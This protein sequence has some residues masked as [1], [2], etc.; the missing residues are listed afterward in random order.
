MSRPLAEELTEFQ[1]TLD[2][3][4]KQYAEDGT[5][6]ADEHAHLD[7]LEGKIKQLVSVV[8]RA[9]AGNGNGLG[10]LDTGQLHAGPVDAIKADSEPSDEI[11]KVFKAGQVSAAPIEATGEAL[12]EKRKAL[13]KKVQDAEKSLEEVTE[14]LRDMEKDPVKFAR[15]KMKHNVPSPYEE[16][17]KDTDEIRFLDDLK[18]GTKKAQEYIQYISDAAKYVQEFGDVAQLEK[19][20]KVAGQLK[21][22]SEKLG[23]PLKKFE[24]LIVNLKDV[25]KWYEAASDF[26]DATRNLKFGPGRQNR[27]TVKAWVKS[28]QGV[29]SASEPF[30]NWA[31]DKLTGA[32]SAAL[33]I[34]GAQLKVGLAALDAGVKVVS[35]YLDRYDEIMKKIDEAAHGR[36]KTPGPPP[37]EPAVWQSREERAGEAR[38]WEITELTR[39]AVNERDHAK[40]QAKEA[41][42]QQ[43]KEAREAYDREHK[44]FIDEFEAKLFPP[45]YLQRRPELRKKLEKLV[46]DQRASVKLNDQ[47]TPDLRNTDSRTPADH[48]WNCLTPVN[49]A[50]DQGWPTKD[51][52]SLKEAEHEIHEF[53]IVKP[54]FPDFNQMHQISLDKHLAKV[55]KPFV[56]PE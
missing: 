40:R 24:K 42:D 4:R 13:E 32:A 16:Y 20:K 39:R 47:N 31:A 33:S 37:K 45:I 5:I 27:D 48:W 36:G 46:R 52:V 6:T 3:F 34:V 1:T 17:A 8:R 22:M 53:K 30:G 55:A 29:A 54:T 43:I 12:K 51:S 11:A 38:A 9:G 49:R 44:K 26:A 15:A 50:V 25:T 35:A 10:R 41:K 19:A 23:G 2:F 7:V 21:A 28:I 18:T 56:P 14:A